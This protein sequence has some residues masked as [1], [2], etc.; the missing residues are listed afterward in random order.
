MLKPWEIPKSHSYLNIGLITSAGS[1]ITPF[2]ADLKKQIL[3]FDKFYLVD[4]QSYSWERHYRD[5][6]V[7]SGNDVFKA[8]IAD[9]E[10]LESIGFLTRI[11][12]EALYLWPKRSLEFI[13]GWIKDGIPSHMVLPMQNQINDF[14]YLNSEWWN[15]IS[16]LRQI[17]HDSI[18]EVNEYAKRHNPTPNDTRYSALIFKSFTNIIRNEIYSLRLVHMFLDY[19]GSWDNWSPSLIPLKVNPIVDPPSF[20]GIDQTYTSLQ[21]S[22]EKEV[23]ELAINQIKTISDLH[24]LEDLFTFK[25]DEN[26]RTFYY[27]LRTWVEDVSSLENNPATINNR[28]QQM[29]GSFNGYLEEKRIQTSTFTLNVAWKVINPLLTG[30]WVKS[31]GQLLGGITD[32]RIINANTFTNDLNARGNEVAYLAYI[33]HALSSKSRELN[34]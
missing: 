23:L 10:Y 18:Q 1:P 34:R 27:N 14:F 16:N 4:I 7:R 24:S 30:N 20:F 26:V 12:F 33:N 32:T 29:L 2:G 9:I 13:K 25:N 6:I 28:L 19:F 22:T 3:F 11:D 21:E 8:T 15:V 5:E 31:L 17:E